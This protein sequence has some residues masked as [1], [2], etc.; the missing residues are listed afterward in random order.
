MAT[1]ALRT[2]FALGALLSITGCATTA[3]NGYAEADHFGEATRQTMAAQVI[4]PAPSYEYADPAT[5]GEH[6]AAAIARYR[7]DAVKKPER[8]SPGTGAGNGGA[9]GLSGGSGN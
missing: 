8:L 7:A 6:A 4:D 9:A 3:M 2:A 1:D 5:S